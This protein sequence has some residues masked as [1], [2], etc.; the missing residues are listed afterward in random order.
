[1]RESIFKLKLFFDAKNLYLT[2]R[3]GA[4]NANKK[5]EK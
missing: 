3:E 2:N 1:M 4:N 5:E